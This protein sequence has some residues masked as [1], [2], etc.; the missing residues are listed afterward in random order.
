MDRDGKR[1]G[2]REKR[3]KH[4]RDSSSSEK[5]IRSPSRGVHKM[6]PRRSGSPLKMYPMSPI[7]TQS[8]V[9][10]QEQQESSV[11]SQPESLRV[12]PQEQQESSV[13]SQQ[14]RIMLLEGNERPGRN[15][16]GATNKRMLNDD[17]VGGQAPQKK[18]KAAAAPTLQKLPKLVSDFA[19]HTCGVLNER[20]GK[21]EEEG[22]TGMLVIS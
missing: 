9:G 1:G 16:V 15:E 22:G 2:K 13:Q 11:Q 7:R 17:V 18:A 12:G 5:L 20:K 4:D 6:S 21:E 3:E 19:V 8:R 14:D 10:P